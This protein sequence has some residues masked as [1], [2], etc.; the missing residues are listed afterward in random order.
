MPVV[1][2]FP[3]AQHAPLAVG[4][5]PEAQQSGPIGIWTIGMHSLLLGPLGAWP[6]GQHIPV[7][8]TLL[9]RQQ[10]PP[11]GVYPLAQIGQLGEPGVHLGGLCGWHLPL[12][13]GPAQQVGAP[14]APG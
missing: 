10:D 12:T 11:T 1:V 5:R 3:G 6:T 14:P 7:E 9:A 8:V 2:T 13:S 4:M